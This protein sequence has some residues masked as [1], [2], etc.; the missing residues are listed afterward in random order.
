MAVGFPTPWI[1]FST[2]H[3]KTR[4]SSPPANT[5]LLLGYFHVILFHFVTIIRRHIHDQNIQLPETYSIFMQFIYFRQPTAR[6]GHVREK[7]RGDSKR[8]RA[9]L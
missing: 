8:Y 3:S 7:A 5:K 6:N 9:I 1:A 2:F 4:R